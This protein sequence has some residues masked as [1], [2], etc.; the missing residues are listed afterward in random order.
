MQN[1]IGDFLDYLTY[2]RNVSVNT[3]SAYR[4]DLESFVSF[5]CN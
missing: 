1:E 3:I 5:L 2:E 4:D